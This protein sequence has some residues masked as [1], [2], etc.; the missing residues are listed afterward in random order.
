MGKTTSKPRTAYCRLPLPSLP[1]P[2]ISPCLCKYARQIPQNPTCVSLELQTFQV[3]IFI[4][5]CALLQCHL[6]LLLPFAEMLF[7]FGILLYYHC[8]LFYL[9]LC[10]CLCVSVCCLV[11]CLCLLA[12]YFK[13]KVINF[14]QLNTVARWLV[15]ALTAIIQH[16]PYE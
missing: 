2:T 4:V 6:L 5:F 14:K 11:G 16:W 13:Q 8:A 12:S 1:S 15:N 3:I 7:V 10:E 9:Q